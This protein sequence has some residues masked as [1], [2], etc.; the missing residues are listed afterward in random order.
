MSRTYKRKYT[1]SKA[2]DYQCRCHGGCKWCLDNRMYQYKKKISLKEELNYYDIEQ[3]LD[4]TL[5]EDN[6]NKH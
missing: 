6:V 3:Q 2:F 5:I 4:S 1:G